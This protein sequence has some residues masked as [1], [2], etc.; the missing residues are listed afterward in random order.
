MKRLLLDTCVLYPTVMREVLLGVAATGAFEPQWSVRI[1]EEWARAA[2]KIGPTGEPQARRE[3][4]LLTAAWPKAAITWKPSLEARLV[5]PD[6]HDAHVLAA[7]IAG[8]S[9]AIVTVNAKDF[10]RQTLAEE[11][12]LRL[13]PD[14]LL[15]GCWAEDPDGVAQVCEAV[16]LEAERLSG[17]TWGMRALLKKARLPKLAKAVSAAG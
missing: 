12:L 5:L 16:R 7:A 13:A 14:E 10:P 9:D 3:I 17:A 15:R 2:R 4:A 1:L 8:S 11:G 6:P